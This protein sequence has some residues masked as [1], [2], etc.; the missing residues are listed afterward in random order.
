MLMQTSRMLYVNKP[1]GFQLAYLNIGVTRQVS[2]VS[3]TAASADSNV[4]IQFCPH[5]EIDAELAT[6]CPRFNVSIL[7][8]GGGLY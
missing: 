5:D 1:Y 4:K 3:V 2:R 7:A 8:R 6:F